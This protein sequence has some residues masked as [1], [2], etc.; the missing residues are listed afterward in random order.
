[1]NKFFILALLCFSCVG[2]F[3]QQNFAGRHGYQLI[4]SSD[5]YKSS[6]SVKTLSARNQP[7]GVASPVVEWQK[8]YGGNND[9]VSNC[10]Q[11]TS[12]GGYIVAGYTT[13][14]DGDVMGYHGTGNGGD[15]FVLKIDKTGNIQWR[16]CLG[17]NDTEQGAYIVPTSDG[18]YI[19]TGAA[20]SQ[21]CNL[22]GNHGATDYWVVKLDKNGNITW[23]KMYGGSKEDFPTAI[24]I[25]SDGGYFVT[26]YTLSNDGDVTGN[27]GNSDYWIIKIDGS[28]KLI[29]QKCLGGSDYDFATGIVATPDGGCISAGTTNSANGDVT[30][31]HG[32]GDYWVVKLDKLGNLQWQK[33]YGGSMTENAF[34]IQL[35]SDG[36]YIV[37]GFANSS[38]G[39]VSGVH[40]NGYDA[41]IVKLDNAGN[42]QWQ[43]C[44]GGSQNEVAYYIQLT[45]DGGYVVAGSARSTDGD[46]TCNAGLTDAWVF[47]I[48]SNGD[49]QWQK[50][51]G[52][53][54]FDEAYCVQPL[55]DGSFITAG[56]VNSSDVSGYHAPTANYL[57]GI[58]DYWVVKLSAP[59]SSTPGPKVTIDPASATVCSGGSSTIKASVLY[60][61]LN[62][63]YQW[64]K[65]GLTVGTN[66][67]SYTASN[68]ANN[69]QIMCSVTSSGPACDNYLLQGSDAVTVKT[70]NNIINPSI[71]ISSDNPFICGCSDIIFK[72]TVTNAGSSPMYQWQVNGQNTGINADVFISN[73]LNIGDVIKCLYSD[74]ASCLVNG[75]VISNAI[76]IGVYNGQPPSVNISTLTDSTCSGST[77]T[78]NAA[79]VN[80]GSNPIYQW[81]VNGVNAGTNS[82]SFSSASIANGDAVVCTIT[83]DPNFPCAPAGTATSNN[84]VMTVIKEGMPSVS[85][86]TPSDT[87]CIGVPVIFLATTSIAGAN[88]SY[89]WK[90]NGINVGANDKIF[91]YSSF[92]NN[93]IVT[94][95]ITIDPL[96]TCAT[97]NSA[98]SGNIVMTVKNQMAP[99]VTISA[100]GNDACAGDTV[101]FTAVA[102]DAGT[103]PSF[104]WI[105]NN[106][107]L[108]DHSSV[109]S[110]N[111]LANG[112]QL[113]CVMLSGA[114]T[115]S[116]LPDSSN[117]INVIV[118]DTPVVII[119]PSDTVI[120]SG[121]PVQLKAYVTGN[122][123]SFQWSPTD[124][125][126]NPLSLNPSTI[127]LSDNTI[128]TL[129]VLNSN[130]CKAVATAIV[131]IFTGLYMPDAFTPNGDGVNDVFRIPPKTTVTIRE[132]S[133]YDRWG[134]R[135]FST[136]NI[137]EGWD[138][139]FNGKKLNAGV[140][141]YY[142]SGTN[143]KGD[144]FL[145]GNVVLIR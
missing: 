113:F 95:A 24:S 34:N 58:S 118:N 117:I 135:V 35:T 81:K 84:I 2:L 140:F 101:T 45:S 103:S 73:T 53:N 62:P 70:N 96:Y 61:G 5:F 133:I 7:T 144:V 51:F 1:M 38:D 41:W 89:Q 83:T 29:W 69:D 122:I 120:A 109:Y 91:T 78:F 110:T 16:K 11:L 136:R 76:Q 126:V 138:G 82:N 13:S 105:L 56:Y 98:T 68:F 115:C 27:H 86:A 100:S 44:Y 31:F 26:G 55:S 66:S 3:A 142:I 37:A 127:N 94:C 88:P 39:D 47:K 106:E 72:A 59:V 93:D 125:L 112:D 28:G 57:V 131:K 116:N 123:S 71:N 15:I 20:A 114:G 129:T 48:N 97:A 18:G 6:N 36:G 107:I 145:K 67:A 85:I 128:Y 14:H 102:H 8:C 30:G 54:D 21:D 23:Q 132:F 77:V 139:T 111:K 43:K 143:D 4:H 60:G 80:A 90:I 52:G 141:V 46:V 134:N 99:T 10:I 17:G 12:D 42:I 64:T 50:D 19:L 40:P 87:V 79:A 9:D 119:S 32:A 75:S 22:T 121:S 104:Q 137:S 33:A 74:N 130:G 25:S 108:T 49:L 63:I 124:K 92:A 65:N